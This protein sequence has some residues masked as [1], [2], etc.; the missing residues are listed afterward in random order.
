[1]DIYDDNESA[2]SSGGGQGTAGSNHEGEGTARS[3]HEGENNY[4]DAM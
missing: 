3:S 1:M 2:M 4:Q